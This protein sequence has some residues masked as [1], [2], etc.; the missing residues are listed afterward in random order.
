MHTAVAGTS[1]IFQADSSFPDVFS[2]VENIQ[3]PE[4]LSTGLSHSSSDDIC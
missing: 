4:E 3:I 1:G 2:W